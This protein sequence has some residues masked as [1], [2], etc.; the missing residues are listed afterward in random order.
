MILNRLYLY[1]KKKGSASLISAVKTKFKLYLNDRKIASHYFFYGGVGDNTV[2]RIELER[3]KCYNKLKKKYQ[4]FLDELPFYEPSGIKNKTIW[5]CWLQGEENAPALCKSCLI[6]LKK[7]FPDYKIVVITEENMFDFVHPPQYIIE[8]FHKGIIGRA[9]FADLL[10]TMLLVE[11]GGVWID[12]TVYCTGYHEKI[13]DEP[14]F[15]F[16]NCQLAGFPT[17]VASNWL[18]SSEKDHPILRTMQ[19]LLFLYWKE[20]NNL[21]HYFFYHMFFH[22]VTEKYHDLWRLVPCY[23][24]IPPHYLQHELLKPYCDKLSTRIKLQSDFHKLSHKINTEGLET[25]NLVVD[26]IINNQ[27]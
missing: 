27:F 2:L 8:K 5:W 20:N 10:R 11:Y 6:S 21:I 23:S 24:N 17:T 16:K 26:K 7:Q 12:S 18:I 1:Y 14:L 22:M 9:H 3:W 19:D 4:R 25:N 13:F 15:V